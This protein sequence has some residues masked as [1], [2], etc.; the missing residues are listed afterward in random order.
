MHAPSRWVLHPGDGDTVTFGGFG[1]RFLL[2]AHNTHDAFAL[3][4]HPIAPRTI[5][6]PLHTH[7][8]EDEWSFVLEGEVGFQVGDEVLYATAGDL[9]AKPRGVPHAFWNRQAEPARVL[10]LISPP[11]FASYFVD[12]APLLPPQRPEPDLEGLG[13]VQARYELGMDIAS[14]EDIARREG[15]PMPGRA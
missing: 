1:A 4:E 11:G 2:D 5:A 10:E 3:V 12:I 7:R 14:L 13:A 6:A 9:V 15:I 8:D